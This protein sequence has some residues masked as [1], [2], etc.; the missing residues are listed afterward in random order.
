M[1]IETKQMEPGISVI[2]VSGRLVVGKELERL[3]SAVDQLVQQGQK[4]FVFDLTSLDYL[5]SAGIGTFVACLSAIKKADGDLRLAGVNARIE[6]L[7]K[8]TGVDSLMQMFPTVQDAA[9]AG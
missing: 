8:M 4:R 6:R 3:E 5:D 1:P 9:A 2:C 7:F